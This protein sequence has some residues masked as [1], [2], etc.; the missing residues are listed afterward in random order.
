MKK[1][2]LS[3]KQV[4]KFD[5]RLLKL[6]ARKQ[7]LPNGRTAELELIEHPGAVLIIPFLDKERIIMLRQYRAVIDT[8]MYELPAGTLEK[9]EKH[10]ACAHRELRE[11]TGYAAAKIRKLGLIY[12]APGYTTEKIVIFRAEGLKESPLDQDKDEIIT[13]KILSVKQIRSLFAKKK[14]VD[15]KTICALAFCGVL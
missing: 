9:K 13:S 8:Y 14:I 12:P 2:P 6:Y 15:A 5:G 11:E 1:R 3:F 10:I 4:K 7:R